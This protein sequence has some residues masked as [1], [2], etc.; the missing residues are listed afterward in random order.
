LASHY[1]IGLPAKVPRKGTP[2]A[3]AHLGTSA[4]HESRS[5][6]PTE[7]LGCA[8]KSA[9]DLVIAKSATAAHAACN[10]PLDRRPKTLQYPGV[11]VRQSDMRRHNAQR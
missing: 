11:S 10:F 8:S 3:A 9:I 2:A 1:L 7:A 6:E 4:E 5:R